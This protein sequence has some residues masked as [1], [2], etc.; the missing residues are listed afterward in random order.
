MTRERGHDLAS[1]ARLVDAGELSI[2]L[3]RTF[4]LGEIEAAHRYAE[5]GEARGKVVVTVD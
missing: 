1:L 2:P 3:D 5:G 4:T